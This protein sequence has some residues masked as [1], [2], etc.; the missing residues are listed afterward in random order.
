MVQEPLSREDGALEQA[1][2]LLLERLGSSLERTLWHYAIPAQ[3]CDDLVQEIF[4]SFLRCHAQVKDPEAWLL[5]ALR[6]QCLQYWR[7]RRRNL[8]RLVDES[9]L[10]LLGPAEPSAAEKIRCAADLADAIAKIPER[11]RKILR[12]RYGLELDASELAGAMGYAPTSVA[13]TVRRCLVALTRK[14]VAGGYGNE[15]SDV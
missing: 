3:D 6:N 14:L 10:E 11:C 15:A 13:K 1:V 5:A 7:R 12:L 8:Y 2:P 9:L 4:V